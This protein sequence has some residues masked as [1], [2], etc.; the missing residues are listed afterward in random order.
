MSLSRWL[1]IA[2]LAIVGFLGANCGGGGSAADGGRPLAP[3]LGGSSGSLTV[4]LPAPGTSGTMRLEGSVQA[5]VDYVVSPSTAYYVIDLLNEAGGAEFPSVRLD[6]VAGQSTVSTTFRGLRPGRFK[7]WVRALNSDASVLAEGVTLVDIAPGVVS[8]VSLSMTPVPTSSPSP[9]PTAVPS[10]SPTPTSYTLARTWGSQGNSSSQFFYPHGLAV[11][12]TNGTVYVSDTGNHLIKRYQGD[13]TWMG[14][15]GGILGVRGL[16][17]R[18]DGHLVFGDEDSST[19]RMVEMDST[20][21]TILRTWGSFGSGDGQF[22]FPVATAASRTQSRVFVLDYHNKRVQVFDFANGSWNFAFK[23]G[24]AGTADGQ[25]NNP[26]GICT[27]AAGN[28]W[29]ADSANNRVQKFS[30]TGTHLMTIGSAGSALGQLSGP[31]GVAVDWQGCVYVAEFWN[32]RIQKFAPD[33]TPL[34]LI[35]VGQ[36]NRPYTLGCYGTELF[37]ADTYNHRVVVFAPAP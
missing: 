34:A 24:S 31:N 6:P 5:E 7:V 8:S 15:F 4:T 9:S 18:N 10:P 19:T 28:V 35:G 2:L 16:A 25:F 23:W 32:S 29:V 17:V 14:T 27:D 33:G 21:G 37:V 22:H 30:G 20:N 3:D 26:E 12:Q 36:L 13:G 11:D 1:T